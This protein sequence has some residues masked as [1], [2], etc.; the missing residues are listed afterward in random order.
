MDIDKEIREK[1]SA[2]LCDIVQIEP[3]GVICMS[4]VHEGFEEEYYHW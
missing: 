3:A 4:G 1:Y 2:P